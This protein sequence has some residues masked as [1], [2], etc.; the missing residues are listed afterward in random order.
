MQ[1][2]EPSNATRTNPRDEGGA[3]IAPARISAS[4]VRATR[5]VEAARWKGSKGKTSRAK[6]TRRSQAAQRAA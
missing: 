2:A 6:A 4:K 1:T 5:A 3:G